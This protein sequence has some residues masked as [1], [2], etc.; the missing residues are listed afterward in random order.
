MRIFYHSRFSDQLKNI[1]EHIAEDKPGASLAFK[2]HL[3]KSINTLPDNPY[4]Y[5]ASIYFND[6]N[7]RDMIYKGYTVVYRINLEEER[8]EVLRI[9][10]KNKPPFG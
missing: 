3:K 8:I 9:F 4:K 5:R 10:N 1:L 2:N 6:K 7:I